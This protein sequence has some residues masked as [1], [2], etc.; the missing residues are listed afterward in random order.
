MLV[1]VRPETGKW[2]G[3]RKPLGVTKMVRSHLVDPS[4]VLTDEMSTSMKAVPRQVTGG[5]TKWSYFIS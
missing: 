4:N 2:L 3:G 5:E 1:E